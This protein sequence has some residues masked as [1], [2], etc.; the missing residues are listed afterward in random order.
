VNMP[1]TYASRAIG[2]YDMQTKSMS[3]TASGSRESRKFD[4]R[5][6]GHSVRNENEKQTFADVLNEVS[7]KQ[8]N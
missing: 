5:S 2:S 7:A 8:R 3:Q 1:T 4:R 6:A